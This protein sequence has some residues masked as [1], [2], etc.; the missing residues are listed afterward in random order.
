MLTVGGV[1]NFAAV[2]RRFEAKHLQLNLMLAAETL[3]FGEECA[4]FFAGPDAYSNRITGF[5]MAPEHIDRAIAFFDERN[6]ETK[7]EVSSF[8]P[9]DLLAAVAARRFELRF[10]THVMAMPVRNVSRLPPP[11]G[12]TI[13]R[14]D[15]SDLRAVREAA[16]HNDRCFAPDR[17]VSEV[18]IALTTKHLRNPANETFVARTEGDRQLVGVGCSESSEG[19]TLVFGGAV[20]PEFRGRGIQR[21][22]MNVRVALAHE[23]GS[24]LVFVMTGPGSPSERNACRAGFQIIGSRAYFVR[25]LRLGSE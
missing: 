10:F 20:R 22:L 1:V 14:L 3:R 16:E 2:A 8:A 6:V 9:G 25:A 13:E 21:A 19:V 24:E 12:V 23:R 4:A 17:P 18:S 5:G 7:L 15:R 11:A